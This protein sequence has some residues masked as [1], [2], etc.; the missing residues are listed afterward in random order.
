VRRWPTVLAILLAG[1]ALSS[2]ALV[3]TTAPQRITSQ[4]PFGLPNKTIPG[5]NGARVRF[6]TQ[7][8]YFID[9]T[10]NL[11]P[12]SRIVT[13]PAALD[14]VISQLILGPT[15][16]E[17]SAGYSSD[18]PKKLV[19]LSANVRGEIGY[20]NFATPLNS[21]SR[22]DQVLAV[23]QLVLTSY[24]IGAT[25]GI[26][27]KVD[28]VTQHVLTPNGTRTTLATPRAFESLLDD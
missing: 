16:I 13:Y 6:A 5:T 24:D 2:C 23:G 14:T 8:V 15:D 27:I 18:L 21:L 7:P 28:G 25:Q 9:A 1:A 19:L 20:V 3:S 17:R 22:E 4:I 11:A 10:D 12:S 26:V